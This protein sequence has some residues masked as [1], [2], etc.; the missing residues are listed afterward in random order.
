MRILTE[1]STRQSKM[2][3]EFARL[4][5]ATLR[6]VTGRDELRSLLEA[7]DAMPERH[8]LS[9]GAVYVAAQRRWTML[10]GTDWKAGQRTTGDTTWTASDHRLRID[11]D[12]GCPRWR[13]SCGD[14]GYVTLGDTQAATAAHAT[15]RRTVEG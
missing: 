1:V 10:T 13:C 6:L 11:T 5:A 9:E 8:R 2:R 14:K 12:S 4:H 3:P 7:A 15:H